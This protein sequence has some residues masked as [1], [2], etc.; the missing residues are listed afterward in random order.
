MCC[1]KTPGCV[2][3][4]TAGNKKNILFLVPESWLQNVPVVTKMIQLVN[5]SNW[6]QIVVSCLAAIVRR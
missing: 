2:T 6:S 5:W 4:N 3:S 1:L